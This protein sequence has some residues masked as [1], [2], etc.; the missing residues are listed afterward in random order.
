LKKRSSQFDQLMASL[1]PRR[2]N[3]AQGVSESHPLRWIK[4]DL[5]G[6][7]HD[8]HAYGPP[9]LK[10]MGNRGLPSATTPAES[11]EPDQQPQ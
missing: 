8:Y 7:Y 10:Y 11:I 6:H 1:E 4:E 2:H 3:S 5:Y 9:R